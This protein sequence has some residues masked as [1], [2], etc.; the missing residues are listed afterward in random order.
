MSRSAADEAYDALHEMI[1]SGAI[2]AG[3]QIVESTIADTLGMSRT[4]VR[5]AIRRLQQDG[6]V[7]AIRNKG[8]FLKKSS[9]LELSRGYEL[10]SLLS[11]M[12]C[13]HLA[14][15]HQ[16]LNAQDMRSL[17]DTLQRME[18]HLS[19]KR[20]REWVEEDIRFHRRLIEMADVWQLSNTYDHLSL[21]VNQV[22]WLVTP[23]FVDCARSC[24]DH[25]TLLSHISAGEDELAFQFA[26]EHHMR[27]AQLI[28]KMGALSAGMPTIC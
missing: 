19:Q 4:P 5:E 26:R 22:L 15:G 8:C 13:R 16:T 1:S 11:A 6:L 21:Y 23:L 25:R 10:I 20:T 3:Q 7:E 9:F 18:D 17:N 2:S 24:R 14:L 12:A 28:E 27:T